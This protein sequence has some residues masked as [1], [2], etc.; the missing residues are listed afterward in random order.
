MKVKV[1]VLGQSKT[2][3]RAG[4]I[5][6]VIAALVFAVASAAVGSS[7]KRNPKP[8]LGI[9]FTITSTISSSPTIQ[10][11][12][13]LYP[14]MPR[15]LWYSAHNS[16]NVPIVVS[17]MRITSVVA[18]SGCSTANLNYSLATFSGSL[19]VPAL[20]TDT[21]SVPISLIESHTNQ[22]ACENMAFDFVYTG[23]AHYA[24]EYETKTVVT[25]SLNPSIVGHSVTYTATVIAGHQSAPNSP[26]GTV[27]FEDGATTICASVAV[28]STGTGTATATCSPPAYLV[29]G[30]HYITAVYSNSDGNFSGSTSPGHY[31]TVLAPRSATTTALSS[32]PNPSALDG[33]VI[34]TATVAKSSG[35][36]TP[37]GT[38]DFY[39]GTPGGTHTL[40][41]TDVLNSSG[42]ATLATSSLPT[43]T[44][45]L[46]AVYIGVT[47][48]STSTSPVISQV[49]IAPPDKCTRNHSNWI[50]GNPRWPT[51][52]VS[53]GD[54][55]V[56]LFGANYSVHGSDGNDCFYGG[57][58]NN[59]FSDGNG[60]DCFNVGDGNNVLSDGNGNDVVKAGKGNN[61]ITE[62]GGSDQITV[63]NGSDTVTV[64]NGS[65]SDITVGNGSDAVTV[66]SGSY[67]VISLGSGADVVTMQGGS[68]DT[69]IDGDGDETIDLGS[70]GYNIYNGAAHVANV[71]HLPAPPSSWHGTATAYYHDTI[72]NCTVVTP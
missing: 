52:S 9:G 65:N 42:Q 43:G 57:N 45:N 61:T 48:F 50:D 8:D 46:Y 3:G 1:K 67:N 4:A 35:P 34:L 64:G 10:I 2:V 29:A 41:G 18:P 47:D 39:S 5:T 13:L 12:A 30:T 25:S 51:I 11:P 71:C 38:I 32:S 16:L 56:Y 23:V 24:K 66:G 44:D 54:N 55:F 63:G 58:G 28:T 62:G 68:H 69:I 14:G 72:T 60:N 26:T 19:L 49:V 40:I 31:Q 22:D 6:L 70:G 27:T 7:Q 37:S 20:G 21:A 36:G 59:V 33:F 17:S 53:K 15:Y